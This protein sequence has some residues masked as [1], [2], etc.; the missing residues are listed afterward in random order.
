MFFIDKKSNLDY[1]FL[2]LLSSRFFDWQYLTIY[3][4]YCNLFD[5][6]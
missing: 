2:L 6:K 5:Y 1:K 4:N 3:S